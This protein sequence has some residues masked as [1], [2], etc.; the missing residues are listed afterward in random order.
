MGLGRSRGS[1]GRV[2]GAR[3]PGQDR[4][5]RVMYGSLCVSRVCRVWVTYLRITKKVNIVRTRIDKTDVCDGPA[6]RCGKL[7]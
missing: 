7:G 4:G 1:A 6:T 5:S 2:F 3:F